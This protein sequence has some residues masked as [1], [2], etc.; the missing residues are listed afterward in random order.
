MKANQ[1]ADMIAG[2]V[3]AVVRTLI[4]ASVDQQG[5]SKRRAYYSWVLMATAALPL[6]LFAV[7]FLAGI[8]SMLQGQE[9]AWVITLIGFAATGLFGWL[10]AHQML[11]RE[12]TW[13]ETGV[14]F[15]WFRNEAD[16]AWSDIEKVEIRPHR[17]T[18]ARIRFSDGRTFGVAAQMTGCNALLREL[19]RRGIPF[20]RW[21]TTQPLA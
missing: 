14:H 12:V 16:L 1:G 6:L 15:R 10:I 20:H 3:S 7:F 8:G 11:G 5:G 13:D 19:A 4:T 17:R 18:H 9:G 2:I 21:G